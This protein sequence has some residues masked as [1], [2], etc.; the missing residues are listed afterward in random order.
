MLVVDRSE[1]SGHA[2]IPERT[3]IYLEKLRTPLL[4]QVFISFWILND[5]ADRFQ[6]RH[7]VE[8][9]VVPAGAGCGCEKQGG[10]CGHTTV[11]SW[12]CTV[13]IKVSCFDINL[14]KL[15]R[16]Q[17][18]YSPSILRF[19]RSRSVNLFSRPALSTIQF[20]GQRQLFAVPLKFSCSLVDNTY[21]SDIQTP[22]QNEIQFATK[23]CPLLILT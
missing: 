6:R 15:N 16:K 21:H 4:K 12:A 19:K 13:Q 14:A 18:V 10:G 2:S 17:Y 23:T 8:E 7:A 3:Y 22:K 11:R 20:P 9:L 1:K 5:E